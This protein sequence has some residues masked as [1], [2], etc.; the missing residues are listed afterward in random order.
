MITYQLKLV[1]VL[2]ELLLMT[3]CFLASTL[4]TANSVL[5]HFAGCCL[6]CWKKPPNAE[7]SHRPWFRGGL[8]PRN[9]AV[10]NENSN[11]D[12]Y[13]VIMEVVSIDEGEDPKNYIVKEDSRGSIIGWTWN[14]DYDS[15]CDEEEP[16]GHIITVMAMVHREDIETDAEEEEEE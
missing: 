16:A 1:E 7:D 11:E 12:C 6:P 8:W 9:S 5:S 4:S 3:L 13:R 15:S 10:P 14:K 2:F